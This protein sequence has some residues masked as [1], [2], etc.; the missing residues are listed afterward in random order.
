MPLSI[1]QSNGERL[2]LPWRHTAP[3]AKTGA[4]P[5]FLVAFTPPGAF[6]FLFFCP[7]TAVKNSCD[8]MNTLSPFPSSKCRGYLNREGK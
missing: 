8:R 6:S 2:L 7:V 4:T 1:H 3:V 5:F